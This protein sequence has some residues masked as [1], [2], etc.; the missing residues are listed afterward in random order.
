MERRAA[1][2][3]PIDYLVNVMKM[4]MEQIVMYKNEKKKP[5]YA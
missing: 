2:G 3:F 5:C 4:T 1:A